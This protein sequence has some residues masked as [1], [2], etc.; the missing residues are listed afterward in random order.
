MEHYLSH[1]DYPIWQVIQNGNG[2]V[3]LTTYTNGMIKVLPPKNPEEVVAKERE[4]KART[5]LLMALPEDHLAKFPKMNDAKE[6]WKAIKSRFGALV[7]INGE[8][9]D[10]SGHV[11]EDT[12]NFGMMAY[13]S[14]NSGSDNKVQSCSK[15]CVESYARLKKLYD[16]KRDK[17]GDASV[18]ITSY[19]LALKR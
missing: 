13:S 8:A 17:F 18:E 5:T 6:M 14:S 19:T 10:W 7:T 11:E 15:T 9:I 12:K 1:T 16:E 2:P 3:S 4:R